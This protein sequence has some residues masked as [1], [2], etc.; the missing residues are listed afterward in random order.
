[1]TGML[2]DNIKGQVRELFAGTSTGRNL[3][4]WQQPSGSLPVL[5]GNAPASGRS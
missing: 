5:L 4:F 3:V 2:D 1:M